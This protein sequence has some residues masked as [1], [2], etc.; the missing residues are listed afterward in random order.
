MLEDGEKMKWQEAVKPAIDAY[1]ADLDKKGING[2][3]VIGY[4]QSMLK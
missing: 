1:S 4:I 2:P 3:E